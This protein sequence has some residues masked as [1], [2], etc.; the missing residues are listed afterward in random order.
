ME[1]KTIDLTRNL[2]DCLRFRRDSYIVSFGGDEGFEASMTNYVQRMRER[3]A[4]LPRGNCHLW[5]EGRIIG[6]TEMKFVED[7]DVG[8]VSLLYLESAYR[9]QGYGKMLHQRAVEVFSAL[10]KKHMKLSVSQSNQRALAFY[11]KH[12]WKSLG[13]RP[14]KEHVELMSFEL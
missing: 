12:G 3:I 11:F 6:Q 4:Y 9:G 7:P 2:D 13:P 10:G 5:E 1:F 8:Y 14:G